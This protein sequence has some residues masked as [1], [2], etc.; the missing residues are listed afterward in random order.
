MGIQLNEIT[1][2]QNSFQILHRGVIVASEDSKQIGS[3]KLHPAQAKSSVTI[4]PFFSTMKVTKLK[5]SES[6]WSTFSELNHMI[7]KNYKLTYK[8]NGDH[9]VNLW[10]KEIHV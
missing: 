1:W 3:N 2:L 4:S 8:S 10:E 7:M 5:D 9:I 6:A